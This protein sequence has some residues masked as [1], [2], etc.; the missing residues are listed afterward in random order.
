MN[1]EI[2]RVDYSDKAQAADLLH[3]LN[4][5]AQDPM[6]GA[7]ALSDNTMAGLIDALKSR[8]FM[9]SLICYVDD[10]A[11]A[12]T[13]CIESFSTF[14]CKPLI[15][16]H[17]FAVKKTFRGLNLSQRLLAE[18]ELIAKEMGCCKLTLEVLEGNLAAKNAYLKA[19]FSAY[20]LDPEMGSA[21]FWEKPLLTEC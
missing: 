17:D 14:K 7:Q 20:E 5:Y 3:L 21:L 4:D 19:G 9:F 6:G 11:A 18:V 1:I 8:S 16:I 2:K 12:F 10:E 13:N 15:N